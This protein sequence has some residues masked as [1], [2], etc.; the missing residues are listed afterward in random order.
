MELIYIED[1]VNYWK[2]TAFKFQLQEFK[3]VF[4]KELKFPIRISDTTARQNL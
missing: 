1:L 3:K 2:T 4:H